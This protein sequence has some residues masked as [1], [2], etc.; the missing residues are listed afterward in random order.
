MRVRVNTNLH[1]SSAIARDIFLGLIKKRK[2]EDFSAL[3][4]DIVEFIS[5]ETKKA[6]EESREQTIRIA[7]FKEGFMP[8]VNSRKIAPLAMRCSEQ[9]QLDY[10]HQFYAQQSSD[11]KI[12]V[13]GETEN[14]TKCCCCRLTNKTDLFLSHDGMICRE[15]VAS[16]ISSQLRINHLPLKIP[17]VTAPGTSPLE[18]LYAILPLPVVSLLLKKSF[19]FFKCLEYPCMLFLQCPNC[20]ASLAVTERS[21]FNSCSC[22]SCGWAWCYLC[23]WEPHWPMSC[24]QFK[25]WS[26]RWDTQYL[27]DKVYMDSEKEIRMCCNCERVFEIPG[28]S[29]LYPFHC[30]SYRCGWGYTEDGEYAHCHTY[31]LRRGVR[32]T[33]VLKAKRLIRKDVARICVEARSQRIERSNRDAFRRNV[34]KLFLPKAEQYRVVDLRITVLFLVE[35]CTAWLYLNGCNEY[36]DL[37]KAVAQLFRQLLAIQRETWYTRDQIA[38]K[39][40][41]MEKA[42]SEFISLFHQRTAAV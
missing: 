8:G 11:S 32:T 28:N 22:S 33:G 26:E 2:R 36:G 29:P 40:E 20:L 12:V 38:V 35:N 42:T 23:N 3:F 19:A 34:S 30:P 37:R 6:F 16:F 10:L 9:D 5:E 18:L 25:R 31:V 21:D 41:E 14:S 17:I 15:C 24:E 13:Y 39:V 27:F 4:M 1:Y 7:T